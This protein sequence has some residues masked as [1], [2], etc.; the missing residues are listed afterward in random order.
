MK[1]E[2]KTVFRTKR[3]QQTYVKPHSHSYYELVYYCDGTG[4]TSIGGKTFLIRKNH[5]AVISPGVNHDEIY[6]SDGE[7]ICLGFYTG[8]DRFKVFESD[9]NFK[10]YNLLKEV[11]KEISQQRYLF[12]ELTNAKMQELNVLLLRKSRTKENTER[13]FEYIV[14]YLNEN[15]QDKII[16]TECSKQL[17]ISYDY[18]QHQFKKHVG[19][20]PKRFLMERRLKAAEELLLNSKLN[21]TEIALAC[22]FSNSAQFSKLFKDKHKISPL[23]YKKTGVFKQNTV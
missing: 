9:E 15:Y 23:A 12:E 2:F 13:N 4:R 6:D 20:S 17:H 14:N 3:P 22:G 19:L 10:I 16:L 18:F 11:L 1:L 21:C 8:A 7:V 5:F